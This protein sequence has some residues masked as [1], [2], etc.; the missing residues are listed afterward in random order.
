MIVKGSSTMQPPKAVS[1]KRAIGEG[2]RT[3]PE[4][5]A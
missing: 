3:P 2:D 1:T 5:E 4:G